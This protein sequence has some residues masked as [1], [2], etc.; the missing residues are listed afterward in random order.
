MVNYFKKFSP[1]LSELSEPLWRLT[2]QNTVW[3]WESE[4][5]QAFEKIKNALTTLPVLAYF[6]KNKEH[7]IQTDAFKTGLGAVLLQEGQPVVYASRALMDTERRYSNIERE[8]LSVVFG[9]ERLHHYTFGHSITVEMDHQPL[10]SIW[11]QTIATSSLRLQRLLLR[12]AQYDIHIKYLRGKENVIA[13]ALLW[14][15]P[16]KPEFRDYDTTP[17][18]IKKIPVHQIIQMAPASPGRLQ[19]FRE[20]TKNDPTL[21]IL[22][23]VVHKGWPKTIQDCPCSIQSYWYFRDEITYEDGI[24]YKGTWL[25]IPETEKSNLISVTHVFSLWL[26]TYAGLGT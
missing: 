15:T 17:T 21:Q 13:D 7:I 19:E 8:L 24:L 26:N 10:N 23:Q 2:K 5:Q 16:L 4:Q 9:L 20:A 1:V 12:L 3:A 6:D 18:N 14:V 11:K 25:I 22:A